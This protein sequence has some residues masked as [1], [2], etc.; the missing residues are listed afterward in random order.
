[1]INPV[2]AKVAILHL[3]SIR[4]STLAITRILRLPISIR[5]CTISSTVSMR[6]G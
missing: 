6:D 1:M 4:P 5:W 3:R 2:G